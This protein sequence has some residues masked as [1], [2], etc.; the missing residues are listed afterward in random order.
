MIPILISLVFTQDIQVEN[1]T[2][3]VV[4]DTG[5]KLEYLNNPALCKN[6]HVDFTNT[7][8]DDQHGHGTN[9]A[10]LIANHINTERQCITIFKVFSEEKKTATIINR[11]QSKVIW[12]VR[13]IVEAIKIK[14]KYINMSYGGNE[15]NDTEKLTIEMALKRDI[16]IIV[17]MGNEGKDFDQVPC[18]FYPACYPLMDKSNWYTVANRDN[19]GRY[20]PTSNI[21]GPEKYSYYGVNQ[22]AWGVVMSGTSQATANFTGW[23]AKKEDLK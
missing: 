10:G 6:G 19:Q 12:I 14:A 4:I 8:L 16:R 13:A 9:V 1:R 17:A 15:P 20:H 18:D 5:I 11:L 7:T 23:L 21:N 22:S 3:I 2:R